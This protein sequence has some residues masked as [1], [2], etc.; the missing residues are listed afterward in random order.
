MARTFLVALW[1][2]AAGMVGVVAVL[3]Y[4]LTRDRPPVSHAP[5]PGDLPPAARAAHDWARWILTGHFSAHRVYIAHVETTFLDE[6]VA[7]AHQIAEP[8]RDRYAEILIYFHRPGRP[9][10][11]PP[12]RV[13]WTPARGYLE[14]V[15]DEAPAGG[16][17]PT[18]R[19][20][21]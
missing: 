5:R 9:D 19:R 21:D 11:L 14:T 1:L 16:S 8:V 18:S 13:Q 2:S 20:R 4:E 15:Y 3:A 17:Q 7:I 10:T 12:R 6:A